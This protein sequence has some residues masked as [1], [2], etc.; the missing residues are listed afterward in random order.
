MEIY[1]GTLLIILLFAFLELRCK[2]TDIENK[3]LFS[4]LYFIIVVQIGLRWETGTDWYPYYHH[5]S[6][7]D[8]V[9][10]VFINALAG[11]EIGYGFTTFF[12]Y[13]IFGDYSFFLFFH[14]LFFYGI[15][16]K[17]AK[18]YSPYLYLSLLFFYATNLGLVGSNRQLMALAICLLALPFVEK[19]KTIPFFLLILLASFF[20]TTAILFSVYY[21]LNRVF[22]WQAICTILIIAFVI[23][24]TSLPLKFFSLGG[25]VS[26]SAT[27]KVEFYGNEAKDALKDASLSIFGLIKRILLLILFTCNFD[28]LNKKLP[29]Y[30]I[31]YNGYAFGLFLYF[32]F[33]SSLL[34]I[35]NR[36]S[37][38]FNIMESFLISSQLVF[39]KFSLDKVYVL[40]II[41]I[42]S[43]FLLL[44]SISPYFDLFDPYKSL[45]YNIEFFREMY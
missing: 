37:L 8:E 30:K 20:H 11:F 42:V 5:F 1:I 31:I 2:L 27:Y 34:I 29:Y 18:K 36:G 41:F 44:Q 6:D 40:L 13:K 23:G 15:I 33:S 28:Y 32:M 10:L 12:I 45:F 3:I 16:F 19:K 38:Y 35:V 26:E 39:F 14:A 43:V 25:F 7:V 22:K 17:T 4:I 9:S 24:K 21:F